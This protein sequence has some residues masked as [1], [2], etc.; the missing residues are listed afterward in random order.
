MNLESERVGRIMIAALP[1]LRYAA[2]HTF[3]VMYL[4]RILG[5]VDKLE[6]EKMQRRGWFPMSIRIMMLNIVIEKYK[7]SFWCVPVDNQCSM[8][9]VNVV[10][11]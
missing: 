6:N 2:K 1:L 7:I 11:V 5:L 4:L 9:K 10:R 8:W 3:L